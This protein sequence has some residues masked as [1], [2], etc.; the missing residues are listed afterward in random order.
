M[1]ANRKEFGIATMFKL[2][3]ILIVVP[4]LYFQYVHIIRNPQSF[5]NCCTLIFYRNYLAHM[6]YIYSNKNLYIN[7]SK[8]KR[9]CVFV[10]TTHT[11]PLKPTPAGI[12]LLYPRCFYMGTTWVQQPTTFYFLP[13]IFCYLLDILL[14]TFCCMLYP[15]L[16][17]LEIEK[18]QK[19]E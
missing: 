7:I 12:N 1:Y 4:M 6:Y 11:T 3:N 18:Y 10:G 15:C 14:F 13:S 2:C 17:S 9:K 16:R 19:N 8:K 5:T